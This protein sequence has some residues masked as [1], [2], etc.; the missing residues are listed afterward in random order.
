MPDG[1]AGCGGDEGVEVGSDGAR[2]IVR[3]P[4]QLGREPVMDTCHA[5]EASD[6]WCLRSLKCQLKG[7]SETSS[8]GGA[9]EGGVGGLL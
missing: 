8:S 9:W 4:W 5:E 3:R 1:R 6:G 7:G 2:G